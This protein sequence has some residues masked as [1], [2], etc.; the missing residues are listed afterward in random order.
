MIQ[1]QFLLMDLKPKSFF[2]SMEAF[3]VF[4]SIVKWQINLKEK[5]RE[6][7]VNWIFNL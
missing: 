7:S 5:W 2:C 1:K 3:S 6:E 4:P